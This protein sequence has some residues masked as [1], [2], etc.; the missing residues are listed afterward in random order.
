M[1]INPQLLY[2]KYA[3][4]KLS[5]DG[6]PANAGQCVQWAEYVLTDSQ[7]GYGLQPFYG[8]AVDWWGKFGGV[9]AKNFDQISDGYVKAGDFVIFNSLVGSVYGHIDMALQDGTYAQFLG[10]DS[11]WAGNLTVHQVN[12]V[13]A[14]Y[15]I[16]T[17]R[18]R[19]TIMQPY[20]Y[21]EDQF[22]EAFRLMAQREPTAVEASNQAYRDPITLLNTLYNNGGKDAYYATHNADG[23]SKPTGY[24][25]VG[26]LNGQAIFQQG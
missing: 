18:L 20:T 25:Q 10:A 21:N 7:Y 11:N 2:Q 14:Q 8:N 3:G 13:G 1:P 16:G 23:S 24:T 6:I 12:H 22:Y 19:E 5:Y 9:L 17:L 4:Q 26:T 15:I